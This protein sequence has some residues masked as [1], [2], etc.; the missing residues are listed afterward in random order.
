MAKDVH[1]QR[2]RSSVR[3]TSVTFNAL[4]G[5]HQ[6]GRGGRG[7]MD[8]RNGDGRRS[9]AIVQA[10]DH[11]FKGEERGGESC[12]HPYYTPIVLRAVVLSC[13]RDVVLTCTDMYPLFSF[14]LLLCR[15]NVNLFLVKPFRKKHIPSPPR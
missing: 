13:C 9:S 15:S 4:L 10:V 3:R 14:F 6:G 11:G 7:G 12:T 5:D 2:R 1:Q 8:G